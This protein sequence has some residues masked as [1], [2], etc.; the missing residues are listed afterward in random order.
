M[1]P[2][3]EEVRRFIMA[4]QGLYQ[5]MAEG[6]GLTVGESEAIRVCLEELR[7]REMSLSNALRSVRGTYGASSHA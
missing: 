2:T 1:Y 7:I 5:L 3:R 6:Q 4:S